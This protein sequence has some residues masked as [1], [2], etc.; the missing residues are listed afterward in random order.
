[1]NALAQTTNAFAAV[2][3]ND[4]RAIKPPVPMDA[5]VTWLWWMLAALFVAAAIAAL[6]WLIKN[7]STPMLPPEA[8]HH[9]ARRKLIA[10]LELL[11]QPRLF[12]IAVSDTL[13]L[14]LEER[15]DFHAPERTTEEFMAELRATPLLNGEQKRF[16]G[17]FL[18]EC[19]LVKFAKHEPARSDL[20]KLHVAALRL[21]TE[22]E[23]P[24]TGAIPPV[25]VP[26]ILNRKT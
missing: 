13:R 23:P 18:T 25:I 26:P 12:C 24:P 19:D 4:I 6:L 8:P 3:T 5:S 7:K 14:Y 11:G 16:L 2:S 21:V 20:E 15:F 10:A 1:M 9:R 22:T 17:A